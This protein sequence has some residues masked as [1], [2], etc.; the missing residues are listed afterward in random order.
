MRSQRNEE[1][2]PSLQVLF[3]PLSDYREAVFVS[4]GRQLSIAGRETAMLALHVFVLMERFDIQ[5]KLCFLSVLY[6]ENAKPLPGLRI[7][8]DTV[9][10]DWVS[11]YPGTGVQRTQ[12]RPMNRLILKI[13]GNREK[14]IT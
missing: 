12:L 8:A 5:F 9:H 1:L 2:L 11:H 13:A 6:V 3:L 7:V 10:R 4:F 14:K